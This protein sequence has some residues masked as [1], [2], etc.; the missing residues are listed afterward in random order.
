MYPRRSA[1]ELVGELRHR[2][3]NL[4][5]FALERYLLRRRYVERRVHD[6]RLVL[7]GA[8][9]GISRQ[10]IRLGRRE[11][12]QKLIVERT[13]K[14]GM[15][16]LDLGANIGY[17]TVMMARIVGSAGH[18][19]AVEPHPENFALLRQNV[20]LNGIAERTDVQQIAIGRTAGWQPLLL[21]AHSNWHSFHRPSLHDGP[22]W[23]AKYR[24]CVTGS[25]DVQTRTLTEYLA[26]LPPIDFLR[27][28]LEGYEV[29]ILRSIEELG[30]RCAGRLHVLFETH[31]EFYGARDN[32]IR[33][34]L[35]ALCRRHGYR[36]E[37]LVSD[38][39][40]G[41]RE[42][43]EVEPGRF[44]FERRG[45]GASHILAQFRNRAVYTGVRSSDAIDLIASS[46]QV[47]AALLV[48]ALAA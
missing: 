18:V 41:W 38:H 30:A 19:Y 46:E 9:P 43:P 33:P 48:P 32:D 13:L 2:A 25:V 11:A 5:S 24:R 1:A 23:Q 8:D 27:M 10:L 40:F 35:D 37:Y 15:C 12:E 14:P 20:A 3:G 22:A 7:D 28:D 4:G 17:Y 21:T 44:V 34:V 42:H 29:E 36:I 45:Y 47:N 39:H 31:P 26:D 6:Y 16:A